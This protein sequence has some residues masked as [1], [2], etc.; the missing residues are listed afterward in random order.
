[1]IICHPKKLI[2]IKTKKGAGTS[3]EIALAGHCAEDCVITPISVVD[4]LMRTELGVRNGQNYENTVWK[5]T[6][7]TSSRPFYNHMRAKVAQDEMPPEIWESY[8]KVSIVRNPFETAISR[9]YHQAG[10]NPEMNFLEH[11]KSVRATLTENIKIAPLKGPAKMDVYLRYEHFEDDMARHGLD[12]IWNDFKSIN[13]KSNYRPKE[14]A[15][16]AE[17]YAKYPEAIDIVLEYCPTE[18]NK[19]GYKIPTGEA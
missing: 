19:F 6:D 4:E 17:I 7:F 12:F 9:Y 8:K 5:G 10:K 3:F 11:L 16:M 14:G 18:I 2:F 13:A 15:S 1:M